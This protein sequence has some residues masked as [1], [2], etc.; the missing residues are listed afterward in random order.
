MRAR[1]TDKNHKAI[2]QTFEKLGWKV[3][4]TNGDW[5]LTVCKANVV[6]LVEVKDPKS[7][8]LKRRN[9]GNDLIDEGWPIVRVLTLADV[10]K[11]VNSE[12]EQTM[13]E[14]IGQIQVEMLET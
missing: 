5:D 1:R 13:L 11:L 12:R 9:K 3:H 10:I 2:A 7:P 4:H 6:R 8:N 14:K